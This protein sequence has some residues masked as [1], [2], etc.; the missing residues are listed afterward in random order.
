MGLV[1]LHNLFNI[2]N[3]NNVEELHLSDNYH[4]D[5]LDLLHEL[6]GHISV[7]HLEAFENIF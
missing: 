2:N 1:E 6:C 5:P 4:G 7:K 3:G